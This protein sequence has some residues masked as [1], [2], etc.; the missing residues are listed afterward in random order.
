M[1]LRNFIIL[2][3]SLLVISAC[4]DANE[5]NNN[6]ENTSQD[7]VQKQEEDEDAIEVDKGLLNVEITL[8][9]MFFEDEN[10]DEMIE[11]A[12]EE[13]IKDVTQNEDGTVTFKMSKKDHKEMLRELE[14]NV[15]ETVEDIKNDEEFASIVDVTYNKSFTEFTIIADREGFENSFDG[16]AI[17]GVGMSGTFY[18]LF[19][20]E[21]MQTSEVTVFVEDEATGEV[22]EEITYPEAIEDIE[23]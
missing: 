16:F 17:L 5:V 8:P 6:D 12:K 3:L 9:E 20:G 10:M 1:R 7:D 11:E 22:F 21:D 2:V 4:S 15:K 18:Q 14:E 13:G 19:S 23:N